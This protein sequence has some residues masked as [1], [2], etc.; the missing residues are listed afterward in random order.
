MR[1]TDMYGPPR[2][3]IRLARQPD[4]GSRGFRAVQL[5]YIFIDKRA[6]GAGYDDAWLVAR[7]RRPAKTAKGVASQSSPA[8]SASV[9][10]TSTTPHLTP[11]S[12]LNRYFRLLTYAMRA[13]GM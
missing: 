11:H 6:A 10:D 7:D 1:T 9:T 4:S 13:R 8:L 12:T 5:L 2:A 3:R